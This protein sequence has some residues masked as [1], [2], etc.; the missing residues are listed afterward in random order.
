MRAVK[1]ILGCAF[2]ILALFSGLFLFLAISYGGPVSVGSLAAFVTLG[3]GSSGL[4]LLRRR[5]L[6]L[7]STAKTWIATWFLA[8]VAIPILLPNFVRARATSASNSCINNLKQLDGAKQQWALEHGATA[9][10]KPTWNDVLPYLGRGL[11]GSVDRIYCP[12]GG[13]YTLECVSNAP[14]CSIPGHEL[15]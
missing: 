15:Q 3:F 2:L 10:S 6:P 5:A 4:I 13:T 8:M 12:K 1:I 9:D 14:R 11:N 7:S